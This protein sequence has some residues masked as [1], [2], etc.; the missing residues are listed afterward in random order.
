MSSF[1][2]VGG[3]NTAPGGA[4]FR[5]QGA[6]AAAPSHSALAAQVAQLQQR[7]VTTQNCFN[8]QQQELAAL[9]AGQG[10]MEEMGRKLEDLQSQYDGLYES[11]T[12]LQAQVDEEKKTTAALRQQLIDKAKEAADKDRDIESKKKEI[13]DAAK[14]LKNVKAQKTHYQKQAELKAGELDHANELL[15]DSHVAQRKLEQEVKDARTETDKESEAHYDTQLK[16]K[17]LQTEWEE[18]LAKHEELEAAQL[19][20]EQFNDQHSALQLDMEALRDQVDE[21][22]HLLQVKDQRIANLEKEVQKGLAAVRKVEA[23]AEASKSPLAEPITITPGGESLRTELEELELSDS[24]QFD[25]DQDFVDDSIHLDFSN[26]KTTFEYEPIAPQPAPQ[27][28][29]PVLSISAISSTAI[30]PVERVL[31]ITDTSVQTD[32]IVEPK[33]PVLSISAISSTDIAPVE[34]VLNITDSSVQTI[35]TEPEKPVLRLSGISSIAT[36]PTEPK[37]PAFSFS[38]ISSIGTNPTEP[39]KPALGLSTISSAATNPIEAAKPALSLSAI[40]SAGTD[41]IKPEQP[42][43]NSSTIS[44]IDTT[45]VE[46]EKTALALSTISS[47]G[48]DPID[49]RPEIQS[50]VETTPA[51]PAKPVLAFS[52]IS[53]IGTDPID[54]P[55]EI[56]PKVETTTATRSTQTEVAHFSTLL[57]AKKDISWLHCIIPF[58]ICL[59]IYTFYIWSTLQAWR[60]ANAMYTSGAYGRPG[61]FLGIPYGWSIGNS[62]YSEQIG[63]YW[64]GYIMRLENYLGVNKAPLY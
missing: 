53:S 34:R 25:G 8:A 23:D 50:K 39:A 37:K 30:A 12:G 6:V 29:P 35:S 42:E 22:D 28:K 57:P 36:P 3:Q 52:T 48:T 31:N 17:S 19:A 40:S 26:I 64:A 24:D 7:V 47:I 54:P 62:Y 18:S 15:H 45:P 58:T 9:R 38:S 59:M 27:P 41:P 16:L 11:Q 13:A 20:M 4:P 5:F 14:E 51:E 10:N 56:L 63:M 46:P 43:L 21:R 32:P 55:A 2:F 44:A 60:N 49:P 33:K 1:N 61:Y